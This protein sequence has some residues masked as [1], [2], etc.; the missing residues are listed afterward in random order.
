MARNEIFRVLTPGAPDHWSAFVEE[1]FPIEALDDPLVFFDAR[2]KSEY[3]ANLG[4]MLDSCRRFMRLDS[5]E[6]TFVSEYDMG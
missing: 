4:R 6:V 5:L 1:S 3:E 2:S